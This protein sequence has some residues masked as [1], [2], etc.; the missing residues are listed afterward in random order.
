M[1]ALGGREHSGRL[2]WWWLW[3][4]KVQIIFRRVRGAQDEPVTLS[5]E[6][7]ARGIVLA[8]R[9]YPARSALEVQG[10]MIKAFGNV[11]R[12]VSEKIKPTLDWVFVLLL[13]LL[14]LRPG[15][16]AGRSSLTNAPGFGR[17]VFKPRPFYC[18][19]QADVSQGCGFSGSSRLSRR[20]GHVETISGNGGRRA[21]RPRPIVAQ[22]GMKICVER[23]G[24]AMGR[25][26]GLHR[27][28]AGAAATRPYLWWPVP[29]ES[30]FGGAKFYLEPISRTSVALQQFKWLKEPVSWFSRKFYRQ[31]NYCF[32]SISC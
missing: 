22:A 19:R 8:C 15:H 18:A 6:E 23:R 10:K 12:A 5:A 11:D 16:Q 4:A 20:S 2:S 24:G 7:I 17:R 9:V 29:L 32:K 13:S 28:P 26:T 21:R 3:G 25:V 1:E 27:C 14:V 30:G 31:I